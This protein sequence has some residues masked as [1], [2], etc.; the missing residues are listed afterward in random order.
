VAKRQSNL[1]LHEAMVLV[2]LRRKHAVGIAAL[3]TSELASSVGKWG[4]YSRADGEAPRAR[5]VGARANRYPGLFRT[6]LKDGRR[7]VS[8]RR[9]RRLP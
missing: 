8:L 4:L 6:T 9:L 5:Q 1:L 2:L 3:N 7:F